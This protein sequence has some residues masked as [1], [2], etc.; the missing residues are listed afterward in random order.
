MRSIALSLLQLTVS[1]QLG[2]PGQLAVQTVSITS[3]ELAVTLNL[4]MVDYIAKDKIKQ[5]LFV[6]GECVDEN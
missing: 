2:L 4:K 1:G 6:Q 3:V 5:V